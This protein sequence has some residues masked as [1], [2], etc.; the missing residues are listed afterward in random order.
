MPALTMLTAEVF[1]PANL[2]I[3]VFEADQILALI[4]EPSHRVEFEQAIVAV[5]GLRRA[6]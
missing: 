5:V 2:A 1:A 3:G 4:H 6:W